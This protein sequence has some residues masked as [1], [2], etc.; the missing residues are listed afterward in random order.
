MR[1]PVLRH[2]SPVALAVA[3]ALG[4][5][6]GRAA[7]TDTP[8]PPDTSNWKCEQCPFLQGYG[9]SVE[10]GAEYAD[11]ANA[12]YGRYTGIDHNGVYAAA[13][14]TGMWRDDAGTFANYQVD[15]L[16]LPSREGFLDAGHEGLFD[17]RLGYDGQ[18]TRLY[19]TTRTPYRSNTPGQLT[20]PNNWVAASTTAAM[21]QLE[22]SLAPVK[23]EYDRRT[24][25]L[26]GQF[27]ASR[28]WT[29]Y[30]AVSHQEKTG[31]GVISGSFLTDAAQLP[32]PID[33]VTN[34]VETGVRWTGRIGS[35]RLAYSGSWFEDHRD[36]LTWQN[37]YLPVVPGSTQ[38]QLAL[39]PGNDLQQVQISGDIHLPI[40]TATLLTYESSYGK[41]TQ[42]QAFVP[43]S[44]LP[45]TAPLTRGSLD[46]DVHLSHYALA[47]SSQ[48]ARRLY[49]RG[50]ASYDGRDD[51]TTSQVVP[52]VVTDTFPGGTYVT[53]R[54]GEDRTRLDGSA[55]YRVL[56]WLRVGVAGEAL[57][58]HYAPGQVVASTDNNRGWGHITVNPL[59]SLTLTAKAGNARRKSGIFNST[60]LPANENPLL[61]AYNY[62]PRDQSFFSLSGSWSITST[63]SWAMEGFWADDA[64]RLSG[65]GLQSARERRIASTLTWAPSEKLSLYI[66]GSFQRLAALQNGSLASA[67]P[68]WQVFDRQYFSSATAGGRWQ[69]HERWDLTLDLVRATT[70]GNTNITSGGVGGGQPVPEDRTKLDSLSLSTAYQWSKRLTLRLRYAHEK[71]DTRDWALDTVEPATIANF[72]SLG[73]Q[74]YRHDVNVV[75][76]TAAYQLG[77]RE[78]T[79]Q[80]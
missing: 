67:A 77:E 46:G 54:Y 45:G 58:V 37:A 29:V 69:F 14:A 4:M 38:G 47:L 40:F 28:D 22:A 35:V 13:A 39:A 27:F 49:L 25:S 24:V 42:R 30:A 65:L 36:S 10:A 2:S 71:S 56:R 21:T 78:V 31:T 43:P 48:P 66:D 79:P 52:Y 70:R 6:V 74:P 72:L 53:P 60:E 62:A 73:A 17:V 59:A 76:L 1:R 7:D 19:D 61:R 80:E 50:K 26:L 44:T 8:P 23:V 12:S 20:L 63:L 9:A 55:D 64:Y 57:H 68:L 11:G 16:G 32:M 3:T 51:H 15:N 5:T 41:L 33:Y 18:P 34:V 75:A